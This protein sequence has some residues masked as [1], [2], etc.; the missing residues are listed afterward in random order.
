MGPGRV[1]V[2]CP[3]CDE[4]YVVEIAR[5]P[6]QGG[7]LTCRIC[8]GR[9]PLPRRETLPSSIGPPEGVEGTY[10]PGSGAVIAAAAP[11]TPDVTFDASFDSSAP[12]GGQ[13]IRCP[14]C[15]SWFDTSAA[16]RRAAPASDAAAGD[17]GRTVLIVEDTEYF[18][19]L[20]QDALAGR[21]RTVCERSAGGA[22]NAMR[23]G[24]VDLIVL[25]LTLEKEEDG[26]LVLTEAAHRG[27]PCLIFT[28]RSEAEMWGDA[29]ARLREMGATDLL[30][31]GMN[32]EEQLLS[33]I[34]ALFAAVPA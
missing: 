17:A 9:V 33:K 26:I 4:K 20:A 14:H 24:R 15:S 29:W 7:K 12:A 2:S 21:Y 32:F 28:A 8:G 31:K 11:Q 5:I 10:P 3:G 18:L 27:I 16:E 19:K 13:E 30:L 23:D 34:D 25:D 1:A 6:P 22:L